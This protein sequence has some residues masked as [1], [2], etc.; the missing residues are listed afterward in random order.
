MAQILPDT[1]HMNIEEKDMFASLRKHWGHYSNLHISDNNRRFPGFGAIRFGDLFNFLRSIDYG[2]TV[3]IEGNAG[4][5]LLSD[6]RATMEYL[7]PPLARSRPG[8]EQGG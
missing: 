1:F 7:E 4:N 6:I 2:G 3:A 8:T 5:D